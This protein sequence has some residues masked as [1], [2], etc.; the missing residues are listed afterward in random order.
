VFSEDCN[1]VVILYESVVSGDRILKQ[2]DFDFTECQLLPGTLSVLIFTTATSI[3]SH[4]YL[5][6]TV[7]H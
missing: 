4:L 6:R 2:F 7:D 5:F 3:F 1:S